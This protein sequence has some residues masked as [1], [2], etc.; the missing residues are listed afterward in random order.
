MYLFSNYNFVL[1]VL[2]DLTFIN[3]VKPIYMY[4]EYKVIVVVELEIEHK[5]KQD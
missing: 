4:T 2:H 1:N 3:H 5:V